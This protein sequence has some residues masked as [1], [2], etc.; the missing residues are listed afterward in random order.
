MLQLWYH[1]FYL[2]MTTIIEMN[3]IRRSLNTYCII[4][5]FLIISRNMGF[6]TKK[7]IFNPKINEIRQIVMKT[8]NYITSIIEINAICHSLELYGVLFFLYWL[9]PEICVFSLLN[10]LFTPKFT[11]MLQMWNK[12]VI[13]IK[14]CLK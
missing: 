2:Y 10:A 11:H 14:R 3:I 13:Y 5:M 9:F 1:I 8:V 7:C 6:F 12:M 4:F